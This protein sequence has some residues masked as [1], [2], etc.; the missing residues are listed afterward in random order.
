MKTLTG[1]FVLIT[2]GLTTAANLI[3][4]EQDKEKGEPSVKAYYFHNTRRCV[5]CT[6][7]EK[8]SKAVFEDLYRDEIEAGLVEYISLNLQEAEG[9]ETAKRLGVNS[10]AFV[11][12]SEDDVTNLTRPAL[13]S[14][15]TPDR[16]RELVKNTVDGYLQR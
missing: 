15:R 6:N 16:F 7:L 10:I 9:A 2:L 13:M 12:S 3:A 14:S 8:N 5:S 11:I 1:L 4:S